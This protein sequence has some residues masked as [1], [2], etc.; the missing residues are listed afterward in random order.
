MQKIVV[1]MDDKFT[2]SP[3]QHKL[4]MLRLVSHTI[5]IF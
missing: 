5:F 3:E 2:M 4:T 1:R